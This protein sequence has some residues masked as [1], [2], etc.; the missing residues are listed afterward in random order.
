MAS[1]N[2]ILYLQLQASKA[3]DRTALVYGE[4]SITYR[5]LFEL[6]ITAADFFANKGIKPNDVVALS[7]R[8]ELLYAL[9]ILGLA[10]LGS[11]SLCVSISSPRLQ[12]YLYTQQAKCS[13]FL[14]DEEIESNSGDRWN[15]IKLSDLLNHFSGNFRFIE[16]PSH[17]LILGIGSGSTGMKKLMP[18]SHKVMIERCETVL[19]DP[20]FKPDS[21]L[22]CLS[23]LAS[24]NVVN[25]L[26]NVIRSGVTMVLLDSGIEDV[27]EFVRKNSVSSLIVS[28]YHLED[29]LLKPRSGG[30]DYFQNQIG[31]IRCSSSLLSEDLKRRVFKNLNENIINAF[32]TNETGS[33]SR[34]TLPACFDGLPNV[35]F[36]LN[37]VKI[38]VV[39]ADD[40]ILGFGK[41]G[42]IRIASAGSIDHYLY[43]ESATKKA[44]R[45]GWFYPGDIGEFSSDGSLLFHGR[46]DRMMIF[47]GI[48]IFPVEIEQ[49]LT[50]HPA[51]LD[52]VAFPIK[53]SSCQDIPVCAV[54]LKSSSQ[55]S[56]KELLQWSEQRLGL[57]FPRRIFILDCLPKTGEGK[58]QLLEVIEIIK[59]KFKNV[60]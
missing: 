37:G 2:I 7:F 6:A 15:I 44:F 55:L 60:S 29:L 23:S 45:G 21:R 14:T 49:T 38:E 52:C 33:V 56:E 28:V 35:G 30:F 39:D 42:H 9:S 46:S 47:N 51:I 4:H 17:P 40:Q 10:S 34:T 3:P 22:L 32:G 20:V 5:K 25:R 58:I 12:K 57:S 24:I 54:S 48:N 19:D 18:I 27:F 31:A 59:S 50:S 36:P 1:E 16:N 11:T 26:F 13:C 41:K 8:C 53:Q 43:N